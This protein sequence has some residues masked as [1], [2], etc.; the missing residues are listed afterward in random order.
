MSEEAKQ[1]HTFSIGG[2]SI[3]DR[4]GFGTMRL[5]GQPGRIGMGMLIVVT[6]APRTPLKWDFLCP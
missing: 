6:N 3:V 1:S 2:E 4:I 5:T